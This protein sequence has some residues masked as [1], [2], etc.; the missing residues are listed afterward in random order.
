M[1]KVGLIAFLSALAVVSQ[2]T[3]FDVISVG[4]WANISNGYTTA[5]SVVFQNTPSALSTMAYSA[6][7][8]NGGVNGVNGTITYTGGSGTITLA[9]T[10]TGPF[11]MG[12]N[13]TSIAGSWTYTSGTGAYAGYSSGAGTWGAT[14]SGEGNY[15]STTLSGNLTPVPE[16]ATLAVLGIGGLAMI[17]R[18]RRS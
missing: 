1:F 9:I 17:R 16:P 2:A 10:S 8:V 14:Y 4:T 7:Y 6:Q 11:N 12:G 5:E 15:A 3:I 18:R 13:S